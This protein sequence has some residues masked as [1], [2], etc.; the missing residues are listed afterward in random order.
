MENHPIPQNVTGFQFK[1]IGNMTI[2]QFA[3]LATGV[4]LAWIIV[5]SPLS[6]LIKFPIGFV[7]GF[8][9]FALAFVP[10]D[11]RPLDAMTAYFIRALFTPN[12]F[13]YQKGTF[14]NAQ[15]T[16]PSP[17]A[18]QNKRP[19]TPATPP[20]QSNT[21]NKPPTTQQPQSPQTII[22]SQAAQISAPLLILKEKQ[23]EEGKHISASQVQSQIQTRAKPASPTNPTIPPPQLSETGK[24]PEYDQ[25]LMQL[26]QTQADKDHVEK[27]LA[28]L[29]QMLMQTMQQESA[30]PTQ[31]TQNQ[32]TA[33]IPPKQT[34]ITPGQKLTGLPV[35][36]APNILSGIVKD[37]RGNVLSNILVE[38]K[39][40][41]NNP[42]R[43]FKT[44]ALGQF[45]SATSL[46][47]GVYR[48]ELE[49]PQ[50]KHTFNPLEITMNGQII[51]QIEAVSIDQREQ[52][53]KALFPS[54]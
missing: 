54:I 43:A 19:T 28:S 48:L 36:N 23:I 6:L 26:T 37:P 49:D 4:V 31:P 13:V 2:K 5:V 20:T 38:V 34:S 35:P 15:L 45:A 8:I 29:K 51:G 25:L 33:S 17:I 24:K 40:K 46:L 3:Y 11:G 30:Q 7:I 47:N 10:I 41:D 39:D 52:L 18:V 21:Q 14:E 44:N 50:G 9:G 32:R 16:Y 12:Q 22:L 27:E 1:L 53:R 42:V